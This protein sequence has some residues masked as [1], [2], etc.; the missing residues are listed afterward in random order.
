LYVQG[1]YGFAPRWQAGLRYDVL[2]LTNEISGDVNESIDSSDR[3]TGALTWSPTEF[4]RFRMQYSY[5]DILT[6]AG[7][8]EKFNAIWLQFL[9]S[10][11]THGAHDF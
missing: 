1:T 10:M 2:G 3:W 4:S 6:Q 8:R 5:S 11:G 7:E 9:M